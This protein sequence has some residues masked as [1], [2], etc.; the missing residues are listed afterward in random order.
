MA[1]EGLLQ[2]RITDES[3]DLMRQRIGY[4][5]PTVRNGIIEDP[6]NMSA[7]QEAIRRFAIS[8]GDDN[9]LFVDPDY[10]ATT[11]WGGPIA[12][13]GFEMSMGVKRYPKMPDDI[14]RPTRAALKGVQLFHSGGE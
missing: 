12:P 4:P 11:R 3:L 2:G 13:V 5:N 7:S 6:W 1:T 10:P 14:E 9:P 8:N